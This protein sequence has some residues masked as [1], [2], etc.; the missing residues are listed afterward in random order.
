MNIQIAIQK[1]KISATSKTCDKSDRSEHGP[2][3]YV[4]YLLSSR[5]KRRDIEKVWFS[6]GFYLDF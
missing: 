6:V 4:C 3:S 1:M 2:D 5:N